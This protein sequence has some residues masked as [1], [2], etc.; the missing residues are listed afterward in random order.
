MVKFNKQLAH[1]TA[2]RT[3]IDH[4]RQERKIFDNLVRKMSKELGD[5]KREVREA[6]DEAR[7]SFEL[8]YF[9]IC[10]KLGI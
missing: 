6:I 10:L 5:T 8:R 9:Q 7:H 2:L 3:D 1:N 4:L